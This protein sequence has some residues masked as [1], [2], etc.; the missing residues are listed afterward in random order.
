MTDG[1]NAASFA[2]GPWPDAPIVQGDYYSPDPLRRYAA[3]MSMENRFVFDT[4]EALA[5]AEEWAQTQNRPGYPTR[6]GGPCT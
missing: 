5:A 3:A 6:R 2:H 1:M 4:P